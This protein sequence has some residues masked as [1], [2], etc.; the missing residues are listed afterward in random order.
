MNRNIFSLCL[1]IVFFIIT[2]CS[3]QNKYNYSLPHN[4]QY[5]LNAPDRKYKLPEK[6]L[7]ISGLTFLSS[8]QIACIQDEEG[9]LFIFDLKKGMVVNEIR[10]GDKGDY[11]G[12]EVVND[13]AYIV[14]SNGKLIYFSLKNPNDVKT[15]ETPLTSR[16]DVEGLGY[17]PL[18]HSLILAC[19]EEGNI[20]GNQ[21]HGKGIYEMSIRDLKLYT[22]PFFVIEKER[23]KIKPSGVAMNPVT[24]ELYILSSIDQALVIIQDSEIKYLIKLDPQIFEKPEGICF[25]PE[26][27]LL[28]SSEGKKGEGYILRFKLK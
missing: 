26:G 20:D 11:E 1:I 7:E 6:L 27:E 23:G 24:K 2:C 17:N 15:I 21:I 10:F 13:T 16:N 19:K 4:F 5:D 28:I 18:T 9:T 12:I 14:K 25:T 8:N 22:E 3:K